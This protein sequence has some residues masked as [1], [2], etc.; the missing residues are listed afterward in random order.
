MGKGKKPRFWGESLVLLPVSSGILMKR[1][2]RSSLIYH[3]M[4]WL[5]SLHFI[6]LEIAPRLAPRQQPP[7]PS[8]QKSISR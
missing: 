1:R 2:V 4:Q 5:T 7:N 6:Y 3:I 8:L